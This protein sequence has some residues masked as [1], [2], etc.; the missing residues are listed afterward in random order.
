VNDGDPGLNDP[1][2]LSSSPV[3]FSYPLPAST[4]SWQDDVD[5]D[6][7]SAEV[8]TSVLRMLEPHRKVRDGHLGTVAATSH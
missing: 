3:S 1:V 4:P 8:R 2:K 5:L 7:L 6:H